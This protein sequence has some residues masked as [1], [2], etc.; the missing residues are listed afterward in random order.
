MFV[1][2][3]T[4]GEFFSLF[5]PDLMPCSKIL[6]RTFPTPSAVAYIHLLFLIFLLLDPNPSRH[7]LLTQRLILIGQQVGQRGSYYF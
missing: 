3:I 4:K 6:L 7:P 5:P 1:P 2:L